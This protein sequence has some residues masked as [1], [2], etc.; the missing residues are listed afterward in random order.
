MKAGMGTRCRDTSLRCIEG[1]S[2]VLLEHPGA[3]LSIGLTAAVVKGILVRWFLILGLG[4]WDAVRRDSPVLIL[5]GLV[6]VTIQL[7]R[8]HWEVGVVFLGTNV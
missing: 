6:R 2:S 5:L 4:T 8:S 1:T 3:A 7:V